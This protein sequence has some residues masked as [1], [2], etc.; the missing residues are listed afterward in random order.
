MINTFNFVFDQRLAV[1]IASKCSQGKFAF[2][3][4][5]KLETVHVNALS[6]VLFTLVRAFPL[7]YHLF[8]TLFLFLFIGGYISV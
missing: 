7:F 5:N 6:L 4:S 2:P 1:H 8:L 3:L